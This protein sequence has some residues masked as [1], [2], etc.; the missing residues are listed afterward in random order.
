VS[1]EL[2]KEVPEEFVQY[3]HRNKL[4]CDSG[5]GVHYNYLHGLFR[6]LFLRN[7]FEYDNVYDWMVLKYIEYQK[8]N[9]TSK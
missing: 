3:F 5:I 7:G 2:C 6:D 8:H 1:E 4:S 9:Y